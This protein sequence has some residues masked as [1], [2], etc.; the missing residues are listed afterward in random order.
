[1]EVL[2]VNCHDLGDKMDDEALCRDFVRIHRVSHEQTDVL[3]RVIDWP[4]PHEP[5]SS[6]E[7]WK[8]MDGQPSRADLDSAFAEILSDARYFG[9]CAECG[10][11]NPK[12]WMHSKKLCQRC[13]ERNHGIVY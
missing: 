10:E 9:T 5:V 13:A 3:V 8:S 12:G 7:T 2:N 1:M 6:W 4:V 11:R